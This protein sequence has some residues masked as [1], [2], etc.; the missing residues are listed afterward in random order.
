VDAARARSRRNYAENSEEFRASVTAWRRTYPE[1]RAA[2]HAVEKA[3]RTGKLI[4]PTIC[5]RCGKDCKPDGAHTD[6][7][8]PLDVLWLC[9]RCHM[10]MDKDPERRT[11][12]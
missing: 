5:E 7:S 10:R 12:P 11:T 3:V 8:K 6:Y 2:H 4:R 1:R 9:R